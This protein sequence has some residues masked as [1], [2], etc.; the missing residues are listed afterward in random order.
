[1]EVTTVLSSVTTLLA[2]LP[3]HVGVGTHLLVMAEAAMVRIEYLLHAAIDN[4]LLLSLTLILN[5]RRTSHIT[6][7]YLLPPCN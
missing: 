4:M 3:V 5:S 1:M 6:V 7:Q 2:H